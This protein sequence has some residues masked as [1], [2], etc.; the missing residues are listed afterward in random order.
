M[1][2]PKQRH[3]GAHVELEVP[4]DVYDALSVD[5]VVNFEEILPA[6]LAAI[7]G[8]AFSPSRRPLEI[9]LTA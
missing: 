9:I 4:P 3:A 6:L 2:G 8:A 1:F 7:V 5:G